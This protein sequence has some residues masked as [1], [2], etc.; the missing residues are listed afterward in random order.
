M[1]VGAGI[2]HM[3]PSPALPIDPCT[4]TVTLLILGDQDVFAP[5]LPSKM[6][7][8]ATARMLTEHPIHSV[9]QYPKLFHI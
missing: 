8:V 2:G 9:N 3:S 7:T 1:E 5:L 6:H 4:P